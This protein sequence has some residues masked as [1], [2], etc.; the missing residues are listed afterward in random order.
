LAKTHNAR[1]LEH[2]TKKHVELVANSETRNMGLKTG[3][4]LHAL[5]SLC[6]TVRCDTL[7]RL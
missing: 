4:G 5:R 2:L 3:P 7:Y 1:L 6:A